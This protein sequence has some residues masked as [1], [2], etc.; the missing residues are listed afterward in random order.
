MKNRKLNAKDLSEIAQVSRS[1]VSLILNSKGKPGFEFCKAI[2]QAFG[3][4][5]VYV[6]RQAGLIEDEEQN[7][8][9]PPAE[10]GEDSQAVKD[11]LET[12]RRL[13]PEDQQDVLDFARFKYQKRRSP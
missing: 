7:H 5:T 12:A 1:N 11:L 9:P 13:P 8:L 4:P 6:L 3:L 2:A 10:L